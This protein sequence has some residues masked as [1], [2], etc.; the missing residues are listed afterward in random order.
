LSAALIVGEDFDD[1][2]V[3]LA[4][5][6][7]DK[8]PEAIALTPNKNPCMVNDTVSIEVSAYVEG[9]GKS[10]PVFHPGVLIVCLRRE[11]PA[12]RRR[13]VGNRHTGHD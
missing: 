3:A 9:D 4:A 1:M 2:R 10:V 12:G 8:E 11:T 6:E 13:A 7:K 5:A